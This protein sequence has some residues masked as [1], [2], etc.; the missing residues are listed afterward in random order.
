MQILAGGN[1]DV[2]RLVFGGQASA[3]ADAIKQH[4]E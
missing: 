4:G 3:S 2:H 1:T